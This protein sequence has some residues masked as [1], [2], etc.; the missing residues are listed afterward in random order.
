MTIGFY[1]R[2]EVERLQAENSELRDI[3]MRAKEWIAASEEHVLKVA[4][5]VFGGV[6]GDSAERLLAYSPEL[7]EEIR[8]ALAR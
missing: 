6:I 8:D 4:V 7:L 2:D 1:E 5:D 3:L